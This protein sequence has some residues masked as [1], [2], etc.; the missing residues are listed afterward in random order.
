MLKDKLQLV[1]SFMTKNYKIVFPVVVVLA[2]AVTVCIALGAS[3][4][5]KIGDI[6]PESTDQTQASQ[7]VVEDVPMTENSDQAI[8]ELIYTFYNAQATGDIDT[9]KSVCDEVSD[10]DVISFEEKA[11]Y[12]EYFP[13]IEIYTKK[14]M[15]EGESIVYV[16]Y[17]MTFVN[18]EEEF[19]GYTTHYVCTAEDGSLYIKRTNISEELNAYISMICA[20]DDVVE[21]NNRITAEYDDFF[22]EH[23]D[24]KGYAEEVMAQV[25]MNVG[26]KWSQMQEEAAA[27]AAANAGGNDSEDPEVI[28]GPVV[29]EEPV[30]AVALDTVNVRSSDSEKSDKLGKATKGSKWLVVEERVNGWTKIDYEGKEGY[31]RSD[32][33]RVQEGAAGQPTIGTVKAKT[34]INVRAAASE[35]AEKLGV[36][37]G[38]DS[39]E[40]IAVEGDWCKIK[41]NDKV[42]YIKAEYVEN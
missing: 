32:F 29:T 2:V 12:I 40:L 15:N 13:L 6:V 8:K 11:N 23:P 4:E 35:T 27:Q 41:Y 37:A 34:N 22:K 30:Y 16:Y 10:L 7:P 18:H 42:G 1:R 20:Q 38:G 26:V 24:L 36:L 5:R 21:F 19:P 14:G 9:I 3:G 17:K 33:L 28:D 25:N 39:A 31:I